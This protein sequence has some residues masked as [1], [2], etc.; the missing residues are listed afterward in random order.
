MEFPYMQND[1]GAK[2]TRG[3]ISCI[4]ILPE[5]ALMQEIATRSLT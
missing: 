1:K 3:V 2:S 4:R 5:F